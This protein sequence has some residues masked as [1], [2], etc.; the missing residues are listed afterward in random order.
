MSVIDFGPVNWANIWRDRASLVTPAHLTILNAIPASEHLR[1]PG[2]WRNVFA[3]FDEVIT[4]ASTISR[5]YTPVGKAPSFHEVPPPP[6]SIALP[7]SPK[8]VKINALLEQGY[9]PAVAQ[10]IADMQQ[11]LEDAKKK[12]GELGQQVLVVGAIVVGAYVYSLVK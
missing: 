10:P 3:G 6:P 2:Y 7:E 8:S 9:P 12:A 11:G 5:I 4:N 1:H